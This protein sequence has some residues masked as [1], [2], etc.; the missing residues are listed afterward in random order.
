[1][2][3]GCVAFVAFILV[4][5][6]LESA[7]FMLKLEVFAGIFAGGCLFLIAN[8]RSAKKQKARV[9]ERKAADRDRRG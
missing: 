4:Q 8:H 5:G 3:L 7:G 6:L 2:L 9:E 1:M